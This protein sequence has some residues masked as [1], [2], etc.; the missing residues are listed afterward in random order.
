VTKILH[1]TVVHFVSYLYIMD[2]RDTCKMMLQKYGRN[3]RGLLIYV[4]KVVCTAL[5]LFSLRLVTGL[6]GLKA[7]GWGGGSFECE[8]K[9]QNCIKSRNFFTS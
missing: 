2:L 1:Y 8:C 3:W 9:F 5:I 6:E 4:Q 7:T